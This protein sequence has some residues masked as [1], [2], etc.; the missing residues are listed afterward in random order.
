MSEGEKQPQHEH[1]V[2]IEG[3]SDT[4]YMQAGA[5][6]VRPSQFRMHRG[7][8]S[9][10]AEFS[11]GGLRLHQGEGHQHHIDGFTPSK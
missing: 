9:N 1:H 8:S 11:S 10:Y 2:R 7:Q 6:I 5:S 4:A 3:A